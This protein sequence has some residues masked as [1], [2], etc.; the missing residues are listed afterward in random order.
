[1]SKETKE[2]ILKKIQRKF[3]VMNVIDRTSD[4]PEGVYVEQREIDGYTIHLEIGVS[5]INIWSISE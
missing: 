5:N 1:M 2:E 4:R 3:P